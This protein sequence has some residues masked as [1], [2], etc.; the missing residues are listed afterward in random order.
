MDFLAPAGYCY[1][2]N[3]SQSLRLPAEF[4]RLDLIVFFLLD[5]WRVYWLALVTFVSLRVT[6]I[7][8][9][10]QVLCGPLAAHLRFFARPGLGFDL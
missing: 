4:E 10:R 6:T 7:V 3:R 9:A 2:L 5:Y 8:A 1:L